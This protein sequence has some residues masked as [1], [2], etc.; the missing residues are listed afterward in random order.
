M[1]KTIRERAEPY[2]DRLLGYTG[3]PEDREHDLKILEEM[4]TKAVAEECE[5]CAAI[6]SHAGLPELSI[7]IRKK[8]EPES[9]TMSQE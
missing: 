7:A 3:E 6:L 4:L 1:D 5:R 9:S 8:P 2:V